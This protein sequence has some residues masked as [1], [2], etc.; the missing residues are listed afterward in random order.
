MLNGFLLLKSILLKNINLS[1]SRRSHDKFCRTTFLENI[2]SQSFNRKIQT[3]KSI[4]YQTNKK[5]VR[6]IHSELEGEGYCVDI[7]TL[8]RD[9]NSLAKSFDI[10]NDGNKD[11]PGWYWK[12][13]AK[14]FSFPGMEPSVALTFKLVEQ[15]LKTALPPET[16]NN[17][18][19]YF[20]DADKYLRDNNDNQ[21]ANWDDK[22]A[23]IS[24][25][26]PFIKPEVDQ[27]VLFTVYEALLQEKQITAHYHSKD[28]DPRDYTI[29]PLGIVMVDGVAY[30]VCTLWNYQDVRQ[31]ALHRFV[32]A[33]KSSKDLIP[34]PD[35]N[36][37]TYTKQGGFL[38]PVEE[39]DELIKLELRVPIWIADYLRE[40]S[41]SEDQ[42]IIDCQDGS[43]RSFKVTATVLN[44]AQLRWWISHYHALVEVVAP[45]QLRKQFA[46]QAKA[47]YGLYC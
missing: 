6:E 32:S 18:D 12:K 22:V 41:L 1:A 44:T 42:E 4:G 14:E 34:S 20:Y 35:F 33:E 43:E 26:Q 16:V 45:T 36:L 19:R 37:Q 46:N 15:Y 38:F 30:L 10:E 40:L 47:L 29:N 21:L 2:L 39:Q 8:Q 24:R 13:D 7:R 25:T 9:I 23:I 17:L 28:A 27:A 3:L 5:G 31:L 11:Q